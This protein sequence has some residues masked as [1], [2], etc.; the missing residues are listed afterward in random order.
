MSETNKAAVSLGKLRW[1]KHT[2]AELSAAM[3]ALGKRRAKKLS[4]AQRKAIASAGGKAAAA[5]RR[6]KPEPLTAQV[7]TS[8]RKRKSAKRSGAAK[9]TGKIHP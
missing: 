3:S 6:G 4:A 7:V 9:K 5:K 8:G 1:A 2:P